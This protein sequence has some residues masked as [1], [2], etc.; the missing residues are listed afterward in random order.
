[1][2][3]QARERQKERIL[4]ISKLSGKRKRHPRGEGKKKKRKERRVN[5]VI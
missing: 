1:M 5:V 4:E 2:A 3:D